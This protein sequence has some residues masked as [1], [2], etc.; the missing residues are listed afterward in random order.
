M[1]D[2][3]AAGKVN[4]ADKNDRVST[5]KRPNTMPENARPNLSDSGAS[6]SEKTSAPETKV[7]APDRRNSPK[8]MTKSQN[9][10]QGR[11]RPRRD[12][13]RRQG[14]SGRSGRRNDGS[15]TRVGSAGHSGGGGGGSF[16]ASPSPQPANRENGQLDKKS[17]G[18]WCL[19]LMKISCLNT[20]RK[21]I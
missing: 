2:T 18:N 9:S 10:R 5:S 11:D 14:G 19:K 15:Y 3:S 6:L 8:A 13:D 20:N 21:R 16:S 1:N 12:D 7:K 4:A 17:Q